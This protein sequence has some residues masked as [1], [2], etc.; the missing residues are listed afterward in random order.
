MDPLGTETEES[1]I[2]LIKCYCF[3]WAAY[4]SD[5]KLRFRIGPCVPDGGFGKTGHVLR[6]GKC[7]QERLRQERPGHNGGQTGRRRLGVCFDYVEDY[8]IVNYYNRV[9]VQSR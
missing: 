8:F 5:G 7:R 1:R 2:A 6:F 4:A 9:G 3:C